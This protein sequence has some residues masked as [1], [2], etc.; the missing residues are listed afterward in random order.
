M[1]YLLRHET[2]LLGG[3][4]FNDVYIISGDVAEGGFE[5]SGAVLL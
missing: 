3:V 1:K 5:G 2:H 4:A